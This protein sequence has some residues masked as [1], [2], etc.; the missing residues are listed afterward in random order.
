M[1]AVKSQSLDVYRYLISHCS[2]SQLLHKDAQ[3]ESV[4]D[5]IH[6]YSTFPMPQ[7][8]IRD[9]ILSVGSE[10]I[11]GGNEYLDLYYGKM[12]KAFV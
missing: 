7:N 10:K 11:N 6:R 12:A 9:R 8:S 4:L 3:G 1:Y 2:A 5:Y